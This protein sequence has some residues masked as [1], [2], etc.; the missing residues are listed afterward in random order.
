MGQL[1][2]F[3][4]AI[5]GRQHCKLLEWI[6]PFQLARGC[7]ECL[8]FILRPALDAQGCPRGSQEIEAENCSVPS[9]SNYKGIA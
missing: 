6:F 9:G 4:V 3:G 5:L 1:R 7:D 2:D 8:V